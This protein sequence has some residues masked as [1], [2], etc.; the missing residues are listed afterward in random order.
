[1]SVALAD[2]G[3]VVL[4]M[5]VGLLLG[6]ALAGGRRRLARDLLARQDAQRQAE[7]EALLDGVKAAFGEMTAE[8]LRRAADDLLRLSQASLGAER[9]LQGQQLAAE[10]G[11]LEARIGVV[12]AQLERMQG[13]I[14][15]LERDREGKFGEL[16]ARLD[17]AGRDA[18]ALV[19]QTRSLATAL[20]NTRIRGQW[21]ERMAED[22]LR[23]AGLV[24]GVSY[25]RQVTMTDGVRPDFTFLLPH[26]LV[27]HMDV[28]FPFENW[29]RL[30]E[31]EDEAGRSRAGAAFV[32]DVRARVAEVAGRAYVA[33]AEGTL[34]FALLFVPSEPVLAAALDLEP[35]L[36]DD[37]LRRNV[38]LASPA[39]LFAVL[40]IVR[41]AAMSYRLGEGAREIV[42]LLAGLREAWS[43]YL[44]ESERAARALDEAVRAFERLKGS[45]ARQL[46][47]RMAAIEALGDGTP[48]ASGARGETT[49]GGER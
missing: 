8:S 12:L 20:G 43:A 3:L 13:L 34:D 26:G 35:S 36:A 49:E 14:R 41:R 42:R 31:A 10:R 19:A 18:Q 1:M 24:E 2:V 25:R 16:A 7:T 37:A 40:A 30:V 27:L 22:L 5:V 17:A 38:V 33:P 46:E 6:L 9:R 28:K 39:T 45:R 11:E 48:S 15:E 47:R 21:G 29:M 44:A 23:L 4:G 32:R